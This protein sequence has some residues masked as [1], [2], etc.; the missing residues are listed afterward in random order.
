MVTGKLNLDS[1]RKHENNLNSEMELHAIKLKNAW[2]SFAI[3]VNIHEAWWMW[4]VV[5]RTAPSSAKKSQGS[6]WNDDD[7]AMTIIVVMDIIEKLS[8]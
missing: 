6:Q 7:Q 8:R 3:V 5:K 2:L 4:D 1:K